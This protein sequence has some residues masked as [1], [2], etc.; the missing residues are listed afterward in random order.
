MTTFN[1]KADGEVIRPDLGEADE[2]T[3]FVGEIEEM[4][5]AVES[6]T[7]SPLLGGDLARDA[8]LLCQKQADSVIQKTRVE[9]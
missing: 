7:A 2:V 5:T 9:V 6:G 8:I 3:A 4:A 1:G